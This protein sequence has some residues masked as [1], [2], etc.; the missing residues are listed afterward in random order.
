MP[1]VP[2]SRI[3]R[4]LRC[5]ARTGQRPSEPVRAAAAPATVGSRALGCISR[6]TPCPACSN[7]RNKGKQLQPNGIFYDGI[8]FSQPDTTLSFKNMD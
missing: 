4:L 5:G 8:S 2:M 1:T 3:C 7:T 6:G